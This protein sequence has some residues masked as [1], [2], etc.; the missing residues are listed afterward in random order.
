MSW[1]DVSGLSTA[2][3]AAPD[4]ARAGA[5]VGNPRAVPAIA[6]QHLQFGPAL[7]DTEHDRQVAAGERGTCTRGLR[8]SRPQHSMFT[9]FTFEPAGALGFVNEYS[10]H[11]VLPASYIAFAEL[12]HRGS[13]TIHLTLQEV[14]HEASF[15]RRVHRLRRHRLGRQEARHLFAGRTRRATRVRAHRTQGRCASTNGRSR[16]DNDSAAPLPSR[17]S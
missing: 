4:E 1:I 14:R 9:G 5:A 7:S 15:R 13:P 17:W 2:A 8:T 12:K 6:R 3:P 16:C 11:A 10:G